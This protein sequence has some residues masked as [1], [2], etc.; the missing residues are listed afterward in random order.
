MQNDEIRLSLYRFG[1]DP[2]HVALTLER[3]QAKVLA[4]L[5]RDREIDPREAARAMEQD[6]QRRGLTKQIG[7]HLAAR[8]LD[9]V[10]SRDT[11]NGYE[12]EPMDP[13]AKREPANFTDLGSAL[14]WLILAD[15]DLEDVLLQCGPRNCWTS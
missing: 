4:R 3:D 7:N 11:Q 8:L 12:P 14:A 15:E 9:L 2:L 5:P 13:K 10:R 6:E 1:Q